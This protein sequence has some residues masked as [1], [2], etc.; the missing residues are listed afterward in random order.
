MYDSYLSLNWWYRIVGLVK[1]NSFTNTWIMQSDI[2]MFSVWNHLVS[3]HTVHNWRKYFGGCVK[4]WWCIWGRHVGRYG[5]GWCSVR[6]AKHRWRWK[7]WCKFIAMLLFI[8]N[9]EN[10]A[11]VPQK[12]IVYC[13]VFEYML[14]QKECNVFWK[15]YSHVLNDC[16]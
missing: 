1:I 3:D 5:A 15:L 11:A 13:T 12:S 10:I 4:E 2:E 6:A 8:F 7:W 16:R 14:K 9:P